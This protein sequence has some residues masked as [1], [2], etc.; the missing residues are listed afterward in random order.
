LTVS[1]A[2]SPDLLAAPVPRPLL[3]LANLAAAGAASGL[4]V[5]ALAGFSVLRGA[6]FQVTVAG[7]GWFVAAVAGLAIATYGIADDARQPDR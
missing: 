4:Q 5:A 2:R 7:L 6:V 3:V 1:A